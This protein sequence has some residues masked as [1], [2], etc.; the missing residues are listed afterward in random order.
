MTIRRRGSGPPNAE[1]LNNPKVDFNRRRTET[2]AADKTRDA[3]F[4][5]GPTACGAESR[6][7]GPKAKSQKPKA[8]SQ[9]PKAKRYSLWER[10]RIRASLQRCRKARP[11]KPL[12]GL[13]LERPRPL[14]SRDR[15]GPNRRHHRTNEIHAVV[16]NP[17][18]PLEQRPEK[19]VHDHAE[20]PR[21]HRNPHPTRRE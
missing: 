18:P 16:P 21:R 1:R 17:P 11:G 14:Q 19:T 3:C 7:R 13:C 4:A 20:K 6:C 5:A 12:Q 8:K 2:S 15:R 9:K 10:V